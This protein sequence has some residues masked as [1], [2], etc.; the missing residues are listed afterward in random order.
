M[1][2]KINFRGCS[3]SSVKREIYSCVYLIKNKALKSIALPLTLR[4]QKKSVNKRIIK[5]RVEK[6]K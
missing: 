2:T 3:K 5:T 1:K 4:N 6:R